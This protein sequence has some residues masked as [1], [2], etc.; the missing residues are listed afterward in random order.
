MSKKRWSV[1]VL[2]VISLGVL[3]MAGVLLALRVKRVET[4]RSRAPTATPIPQVGDPPR[5]VSGIQDSTFDIATT[6]QIRP[7]DDNDS[8]WRHAQNV[9]VRGK[10]S[11]WSS[12][13]LTVAVGGGTLTV[14]T[15]DPTRLYCF[16]L[17]VPGA[18]GKPPVK[19]STIHTPIRDAA[20][21]GV[22]VALSEVSTR[23]RPGD[24]TYVV[25]TREGD[26][27][28]ATLIAGYGCGYPTGAR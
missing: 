13:S 23:L 17:M 12:D 3:I 1:L 16:P 9:Q 6:G 28:R 11:S 26:W 14:K 22:V 21:R 10:V 7:F 19:T 8:D 27:L 18:D 24:D 5:G 20:S 25:T 2:V 4:E 15:T